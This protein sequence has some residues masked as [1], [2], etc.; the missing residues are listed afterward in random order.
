[1]R[2]ASQ[3]QEWFFREKIDL[4]NSWEPGGAIRAAKLNFKTIEIP[5][6]EPERIGGQ[7]KVS[8]IKNGTCVVMQILYELVTGNRHIK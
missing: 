1:M 2:L 3:A 8:I 5:V 7:S 6:E 4:F